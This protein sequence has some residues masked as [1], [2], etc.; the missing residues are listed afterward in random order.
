M[1]FPCEE[2]FTEDRRCFGSRICL[3]SGAAFG[4]EGSSF[5]E[6]N[7]LQVLDEPP[8]LMGFPDVSRLIYSQSFKTQMF[9]FRPKSKPFDF[10]C[11]AVWPKDAWSL[12]SLGL[13][14]PSRPKCWE[15]STPMEWL[16][17]IS[18]W[19]KNTWLWTS[20]AAWVAGLRNFSKWNSAGIQ[21]CS[22]RLVIVGVVGL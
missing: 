8:V 7:H 10:I 22:A 17:T 19:D 4:V 21:T 6:K 13:N 15:V 2:H 1:M 16:Q 5:R 9:P 14:S 18:N 3:L 12:M 20:E 11:D